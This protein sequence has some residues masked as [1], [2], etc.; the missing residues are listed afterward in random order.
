MALRTQHS[1]CRPTVRAGAEKPEN[2]FAKSAR[3][4]LQSP[5][6]SAAAIELP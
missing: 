1:P 5:F 3:R 6:A 4:E 2:L